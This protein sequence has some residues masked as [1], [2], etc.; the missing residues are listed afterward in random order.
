MKLIIDCGST[1]ADWVIL[2]EEKIVA[3]FQSEG[4]NPNY[5]DKD[6]ILGIILNESSYRTYIQEIKEIFFYGSGCGSEMNRNIIKDIFSL[7]FINAKITVTH[8]MMAACHAV[9]HKNEGIVCILG[10]GSN[11]CF[12]DGNEITEKA[13]S[14]GY[15]LGDEGSGSYIGKTLI[16][17][18]F[19]KKMP[20]DLSSKFEEKYKI[21]LN[22]LIDNVYHKNSASK[23]LA[24]FSR[25]AYD[26]KE[27]D[28]I[29]DTLS[30]CFDEFIECFFLRY[31]NSESY[32]IGFVGSIAYYFKDILNKSLE[33]HGLRLGKVIKNPIE[34][35][36]EYHSLS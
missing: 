24:D 29:K 18:Y 20:E 7:I 4:F 26:N 35:L 19:Y 15:I 32:E 28:Y 36:I 34:G 1:K 13:T 3:S 9:L 31:S 30:R 25:F 22:T 16:R 11:S 5:T 33:N 21:N 8:D 27:H 6:S 14:L 23:Y 12:Y 17:D 10:T 2:K